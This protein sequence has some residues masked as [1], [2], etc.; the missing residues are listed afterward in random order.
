[1]GTHSVDH[2]TTSATSKSRACFYLF[3]VTYSSLITGTRTYTRTRIC[4]CTCTPTPTRTLSH[5]RPCIDAHT[6]A[7]Q[8]LLLQ[9]TLL[10]FR[11]TFISG[12]ST[13]IST[14]TPSLP[15][16]FLPLVFYSISHAGSL[17]CTYTLAHTHT[18]LQRLLLSTIKETRSEIASLHNLKYPCKTA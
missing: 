3:R 4:T 14:H 5:L 12:I 7:H 11:I 1:M 17:F 15:A 2:D 16:P 8:H 18:H 10:M 9:S 13:G 6:Y